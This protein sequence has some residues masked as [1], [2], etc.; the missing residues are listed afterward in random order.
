LAMDFSS[1]F[2]RWLSDRLFECF[3]AFLGGSIE[4]SKKMRQAENAFRVYDN[5]TFF[6]CC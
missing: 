3:S 6:V 4:E 1:A 5:D 2:S